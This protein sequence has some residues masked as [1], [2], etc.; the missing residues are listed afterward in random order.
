MKDGH[1]SVYKTRK[2]EVVGEDLEKEESYNKGELVML[3]LNKEHDTTQRYQK[4]N[5][6]LMPLVAFLNNV[7]DLQ[8][9]KRIMKEY[10]FKEVEREVENMCD[11]GDMLE[12]EFRQK[13]RTKN[14]VECIKKLMIKLK[15]SFK[16]AITFLEIPEDEVLELKD[17]FNSD[18][19]KNNN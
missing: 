15:M 14:N 9:K 19:S 4:H 13:E 12:R 10:V 2:E 5:E 16:E 11:Y 7:I 8:G 18:E 3:Y 6:V 17:V 1:I